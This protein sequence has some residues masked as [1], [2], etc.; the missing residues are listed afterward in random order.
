MGTN[1]LK[2]DEAIWQ[3]RVRKSLDEFLNMAIEKD[4]HSTKS[5]FVRQAVRE[6]LERMGVEMKIEIEGGI[7]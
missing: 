7:K 1:E 3:I 2:E 5:E 6:K 4:T